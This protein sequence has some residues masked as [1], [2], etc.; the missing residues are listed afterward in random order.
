MHI[1][2]TYLSTF[3]LKKKKMVFTLIQ[4]ITCNVTTPLTLTRIHR[5]MLE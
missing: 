4:R 3:Y 2:V 1:I 5:C